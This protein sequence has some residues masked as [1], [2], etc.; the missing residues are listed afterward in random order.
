MANV[1]EIGSICDIIIQGKFP[2][3]SQIQYDETLKNAEYEIKVDTQNNNQIYYQK[4]D[5]IIFSNFMQNTITF[6]VFNTIS[7]QTKYDE[8]KQ[9]LAKLNFKPESVAVMGGEFKTF[10][11]NNG[12]PHEFL[13]K[14]L[15]EK[16]KSAF[17]KQ[18]NI[19]PN[20]LSIVV[21]NSPVKDVDM[22]IRLE[23]LQSSPLD[24]LF[25]SVLFRT[26]N[27]NEFNEFI[28][29]FGAD[30]IGEMLDSINRLE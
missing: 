19:N 14:F 27:Y 1:S 5:I 4:G 12:S 22:Q 21:A 13:N 17:G 18:L 28:L 25:V 20:I 3:F 7:I 26:T 15:N 2:L 11:T 6:R 10:V 9:L 23:P 8:F 29:K 30:F 24:S 16:A